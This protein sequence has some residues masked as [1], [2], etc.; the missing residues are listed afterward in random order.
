MQTSALVREPQLLGRARHQVSNRE[1]CTGSVLDIRGWH[2]GS[3]TS[4]W[5]TYKLPT[6]KLSSYVIDIEFH[7]AYHGNIDASLCGASRG[8]TGRICRRSPRFRDPR[9]ISY[10]LKERIVW[11]KKK[12]KSETRERDEFPR[13]T[14]PLAAFP[15][16]FESARLYGMLA[17]GIFAWIL[18]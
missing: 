4:T 11:K 2:N 17:Y 9:W 10:S 14:L 1:Y 6:H 8:E 18:E 7:E 15:N 13:C 12:R 3:R 5:N 16:R